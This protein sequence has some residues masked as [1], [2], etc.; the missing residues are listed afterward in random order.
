[1]Y[2]YIYIYNVSTLQPSITKCSAR[3][4]VN[5]HRAA[6]PAFPCMNV[7]RPRTHHSILHLPCFPYRR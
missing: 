1:M 6:S 7:G 4:V 2:V 3:P 5:P